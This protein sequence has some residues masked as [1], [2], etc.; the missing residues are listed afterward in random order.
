MKVKKDMHEKAAAFPFA[1]DANK[2]YHW[3]NHGMS[4]REYA[5][6]QLCV[7][8]SGTPWLDDMISKA[9]HDR[10]M[11]SA[12]NGSAAK[13]EWAHNLAQHAWEVAEAATLIETEE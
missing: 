4:L 8:D 2:E 11:Q 13:R 6:I 3:I 9:R 12:L 7:P 1:N 10:Y 5:A